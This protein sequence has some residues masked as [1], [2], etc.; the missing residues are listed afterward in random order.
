MIG[1]GGGVSDGCRL[2]PELHL[3]QDKE[4]KNNKVKRQTD[5][6]M[7]SDESEVTVKTTRSC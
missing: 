2:T 5:A 7:R 1:G 3:R 4:T 6:L